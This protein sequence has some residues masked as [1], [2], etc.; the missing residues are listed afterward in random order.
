MITL[1]LSGALHEFYRLSPMCEGILCWY[2]FQPDSNALDLSNGALN[3]LLIKRCASVN[4]HPEQDCQ[5]DYIVILDP[6]DYGVSALEGLYT[7]LKPHGRL[8]LAYEN[9]FALRYWSGKSSP[10]TCLPYDALYGRDNRISK[11]EMQIR[12]RQAGFDAQKWYYPLP[13]HWFAQEIYSEK[14]LPDESLNPHFIPYIN[15]DPNLQ[16]DERPLYPEMVRGGAF[17]FMCGAY[18]VEARVSKLTSPCPVDYAT[19]TAYREPA[20]RFATIVQNDGVV[21]KYPLHPDGYE[22]VANLLQNH[23]ALAELG[24]NVVPLRLEGNALIMQRYPFPTLNDYWT[25]KLINGKLDVDEMFR[26]FDRIY[27]AIN[28]ASVKGGCYWELVPAN[29]FYDEEK[30]ELVF[31]DQEFAWQ[32]GTPEMAMARAIRTLVYSPV[33]R[34]DSRADK[35]LTDLVA[36]YNLGEQWGTLTQ[37]A[38][39]TAHAHVFGTGADELTKTTEAALGT[40]VRSRSSD[41][42][43]KRFEQFR[44]ALG[45]LKRMGFHRP[46]LYGYG[47]WGKI[48]ERVLNHAGIEPVAIVD[49]NRQFYSCV[50]QLPPELVADVVIVSI[51]DSEAIADDIKTRTQLPV[52]TLEELMET[53]DFTQGKVSMVMTCYNKEDFIGEM[54]DSVLAQ[55]WENIELILVNDGSTDGTRQV[56]ADFIPK[57]YAR[58]ID[59]VVVDQENAGVCAAAKA[60]LERVTGDYVCIVDADDELDPEYMSAMAGWLEENPEYD[61]ATCDFQFYENVN[62]QREYSDSGIPLVEPEYAIMLEYYLSFKICAA[63]WAYMVRTSYLYKCRIIENYDTS[64]KGSHEPDFMVPLTAHGG[65]VKPIHKQLYRQNKILPVSH[66]RPGDYEKYYLHYQNYYELTCRAI[67]LL[68]INVAD[69]AAKKRYIRAAK[70]RLLIQHFSFIHIPGGEDLKLGLTSD[71]VEFINQSG[72]KPESLKGMELGILHNLGELFWGI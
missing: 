54:L 34:A 38:D 27:E 63:S 43:N 48:F 57:F 2:P 39:K 47:T 14:V 42:Y 41:K 30:D 8:L 51:Q 55:D 26:Q 5:Y 21:K 23:G 56:I 19:V 20:K 11:A 49:Q 64:T 61:Y 68:P 28:K 60:G 15:N 58:R 13:D 50:E 71:L 59:V 3:D 4:T 36:R 1:A 6:D 22:G 25:K 67:Q 70:L 53:W 40:V 24:V 7:K 62:G 31:F 35:W 69:E 37:F 18:L 12:L 32:T 45:K 72:L 46:V 65:K 52:F 9:P 44:N 29:C 66:S 33:F 17:E 16:F 10:V